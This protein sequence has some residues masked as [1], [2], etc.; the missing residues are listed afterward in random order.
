MINRIL[1]AGILLI[2]TPSIVRAMEKLEADNKLQA[3]VL[4]TQQIQVEDSNG[5]LVKEPYIQSNSTVSSVLDAVRD[6]VV[7]PAKF[8]IA[9]P[10][11]TLYAVQKTRVPWLLGWW[12]QEK[13]TETPLFPTENIKERMST[14]NTRRFKVKVGE[15]PLY[16]LES[17][18]PQ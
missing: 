8:P 14:L 10:L 6:R 1:L 5:E 15:N 16:D 9:Q 7:T 4:K 12:T 11:L 17:A 3:W 18:E 2:A 13:A